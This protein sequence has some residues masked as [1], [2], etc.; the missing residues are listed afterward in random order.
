V[1]AATATDSEILVVEIGVL[2]L[3]RSQRIVIEV[4][5]V[6]EVLLNAVMRFSS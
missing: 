4:W 3:V 1:D 5:I 2:K 6:I